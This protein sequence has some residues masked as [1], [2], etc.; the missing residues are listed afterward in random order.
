MVLNP[1]PKAEAVA[2]PKP[3]I[4][5]PVAVANEERLALS[6]VGVASWHC[7]DGWYGGSDGW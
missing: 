1:W 2:Y 4:R 6:G 5:W 3:G 7:R